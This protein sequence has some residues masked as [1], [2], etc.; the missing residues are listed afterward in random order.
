MPAAIHSS[1]ADRLLKEGTEAWGSRLGTGMALTGDLFH[2]ALRRI[3]GQP[4]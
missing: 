2:W 1:K 3:S 4:N